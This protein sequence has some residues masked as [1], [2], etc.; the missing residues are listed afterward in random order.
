MVPPC[1]PWPHAQVPAWAHHGALV[2][3]PLL[4]LESRSVYCIV[5][6]NALRRGL[7]S[8]DLGP[9]SQRLLV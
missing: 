8:A 3:T 6:V 5:H 7:V 2:Y 9:P 1:V 4:T